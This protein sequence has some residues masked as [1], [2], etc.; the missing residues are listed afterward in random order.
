MSERQERILWYWSDYWYEV[1]ELLAE[2]YIMRGRTFSGSVGEFLA[3]LANPD[4]NMVKNISE[5]IE[6]LEADDE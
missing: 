3:K 4:G 5:A 1:A 6:R 2:M